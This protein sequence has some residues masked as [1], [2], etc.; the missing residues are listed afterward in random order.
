M[1]KYILFLYQYLAHWGTGAS[2][3]M[4]QW[5]SVLLLSCEEPEKLC[6]DLQQSLSLCTAFH[7]PT[8]LPSFCPLLMGVSY[9]SSYIV[10]GAF[11]KLNM[12]NLFYYVILMSVHP[13]CYS[14]HVLSKD[15]SISIYKLY[16]MSSC[17][18]EKEH[19]VEW[20]GR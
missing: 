19:E 20:L 10:V 6:N 11:Y 1:A 15:L 5:D 12:Y 3:R 17:H 18:G 9:T 8:E 4:L 16:R 14:I 7:L 2:L 13:H